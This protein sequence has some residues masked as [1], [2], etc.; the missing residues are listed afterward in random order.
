[1]SI[2]EFLARPESEEPSLEFLRGEVIEKP[3][4]VELHGH[5][6]ID[7]GRRIGNYIEDEDLD[8]LVTTE[9]R[10]VDR[11]QDWV[12]LPDL[13]VRL[14]AD[15]PQARGAVEVPPDMAVEVLSPDDRVKRWIERVELY[16]AGGTKLLWVIDPDEESIRVYRPGEQ[17]RDY[18][19]GDT[20]TA[21][22]VLP[23]FALDV[24]AFFDFA[25]RR[26]NCAA[27]VSPP[28]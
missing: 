21:A 9:V 1:L 28:A 22:P 4:E 26:R 8:A 11:R 14:T 24:G 18:R 7:L 27:R 23:G 16:L 5:I 3:I 19:A 25:R 10:H 2:D 20:I 13:N 6:V 17:A 15:A 12:Y